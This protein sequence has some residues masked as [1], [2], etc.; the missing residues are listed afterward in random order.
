[1]SL[2]E[3]TLA[4][5][6]P[7]SEE[8]R[9]RAAARLRDQV[10]PRGSLGR[11][12]HVAE[13]LAAIRA[14]LFPPTDHRHL[15]VMA[16]DHGVA[17]EGV[18]AYPQEVTAQMVAAFAVGAASINALARRVNADVQVVDVGVASDLPADLP[19]LHKRVRPGADNIARGP[20]M[21]RDEAVRSLEVGIEVV[22]DLQAADLIGVGDMG[23]AN[24]TPSAAIIAA[25]SD[26][27]IEQLVGR[28][29][30]IDDAALE[31]KRAAVR[32]AL[33]ANRPDPDDPIDVLAKVGG[34]E[35]GAIAGAVLGAASIG[36]P[37][38]CDGFIATAGALLA[39]ELAPPARGYLFAS[40]RSVEIGHQAMLERLGLDPL[41]DLGLR[42]GEGA[43]AALAMFL[44]DAAAHVLSDIKTFSELGVTDTGK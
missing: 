14:S 35:I 26:R 12:E 38:I 13:R 24:T 16:G 34:L 40:H 6:S 15:L 21:T 29:T 30:G 7:V 28:G 42:L 27:P 3:Q 31:R 1:M 33:D 2:L 25:Y 36:R 44:L 43:G 5:I 17:E 32:R 37:V 11:L 19:I 4:S 41:L 9:A 8:W 10:R 23:I 39:C 22:Q 20:A 18:S